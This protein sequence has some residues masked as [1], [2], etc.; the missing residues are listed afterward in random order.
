MRIKNWESSLALAVPIFVAITTSAIGGDVDRVS[1]YDWR[2][3]AG[4]Q[5]YTN[6]LADVPEEY[7]NRVAI[8]VKDWVPP[9]P[10]PEEAPGRPTEEA[11]QTLQGSPAPVQ[12]S[13]DLPQAS[14]TDYV[15]ASQNSSV[16]ENTEVVT[17]Q[18]LLFDDTF[19]PA[20]GLPS[21]ARGGRPRRDVFQAA[22]PIP[23]NPAGPP[24]LGAAGRSP[25]GF[26]GTRR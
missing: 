5:H 1:I 19:L 21:F 26:A 23:R 8:L 16:V 15:D 13:S 10:P 12:A 14:V 9:E 25:I 6:E 18:P 2:D 7:R 11:A 20:G 3:G 17:Q 24:P 22:G 4:V